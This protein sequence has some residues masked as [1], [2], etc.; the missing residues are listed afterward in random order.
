MI[1]SAFSHVLFACA[2][3]LLFLNCPRDLLKFSRDEITS[4]HRLITIPFV[5]RLVFDDFRST[6][7]EIQQ[8]AENEPRF[9]PA[10]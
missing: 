8:D 7:A 2:F 5:S 3:C 9:S 6:R 1:L 4:R 10:A